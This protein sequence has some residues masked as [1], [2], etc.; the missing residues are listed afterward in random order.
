MLD[1]IE[2]II[3]IKIKLDF[4]LKIWYNI[5]MVAQGKWWSR[6]N[7]Y[8]YYNYSVYIIYRINN[9][10]YIMFLILKEAFMQSRRDCVSIQVVDSYS[11]VL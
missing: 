7:I 11:N 4:W 5:C 2:K 3:Y 10:N 8:I 9:N 1:Y 6:V